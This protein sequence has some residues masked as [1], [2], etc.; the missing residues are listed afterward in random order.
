MQKSGLLR[1]PLPSSEWVVD[2]A[3]RAWQSGSRVH[4]P[5]WLNKAMVFSV[6]MTPRRWMTALV[7]TISAPVRKD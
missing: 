4:V 6:R 2:S 5:G 1:L 7:R 3:W